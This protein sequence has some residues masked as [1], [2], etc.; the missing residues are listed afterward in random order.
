MMYLARRSG[1]GPVRVYPVNAGEHLP[2]VWAFVPRMGEG[3]EKAR[4][5]LC[6]PGISALARMPHIARMMLT[7]AEDSI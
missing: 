5:Q 1:S 7:T 2:R 4:S 6:N 3:G